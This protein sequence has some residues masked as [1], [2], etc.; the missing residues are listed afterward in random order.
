MARAISA[1]GKT[2]GAVLIERGYREGDPTQFLREIVQNGIEAG[3]TKIQLGI[4]WQSSAADWKVGDLPD[5]YPYKILPKRY[6]MVYYDNGKGMGERMADYLAGLLDLDSKDQSSGDLHGNF[7]MGA[8]ISTL[9]WNRAGLLVASWTPEFPEG[10][11]MWLRYVPDKSEGLGYYEAATLRW[12]DEDGLPMA[13]E[14][15]PAD[16]FPEFVDD[17]PEWLGR[18]INDDGDIGTGTMF[19]F[20]GNTGQ[21][22][23]FL[24]PENNWNTHTGPNYLT[25]RY[26]EHPTNLEI[27]YEDP[28]S[29][30][31]DSWASRR[32]DRFGRTTLDGSNPGPDD[33]IFNEP[34]RPTGPL[35]AGSFS[36]KGK[37]QMATI[38]LPDGGRIVINMIPEAAVQTGG[39]RRQAERPGIAVLYRGELYHR[40]EGA[41]DYQKFGISSAKVY[42]RLSITVE[43]RA[44]TS[45][46]DPLGGVFPSSS[47][48]SLSYVQPAGGATSG[49]DL[50]WVLWEQAFIDNMPKF[51]EEAIQA[52]VPD[53]HTDLDQDIIDKVA[54]PYMDMFKQ[55]KWFPRSNGPVAGTVSGNGGT[56]TVNGERKRR[57]GGGGGVDPGPGGGA[58]SAGSN[59]APDGS[60]P[61]DTKKVP[62]AIPECHFDAESFDDEEVQSKPR[63]AVKYLPGKTGQLGKIVMDPRFPL[64]QDVTQYWLDR[65]APPQHEDVRRAVQ[66]VYRTAMACRVGQILALT[67]ESGLTVDEVCS[68]FM[69]NS[70]LTASLFGLASEHAV[71]KQRLSGRVKKTPA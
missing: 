59:G 60:E 64:I 29:S 41:R 7:G 39:G 47:R 36:R 6:R 71:I 56:N 57:K 12:E 31:V 44:A 2:A 50:P 4:H 20:L 16:L 33:R 53:D 51:V 25:H 21:E 35:M 37:S 5:A 14:V 1:D 54:Q 24:G 13:S 49:R 70:A 28:R 43:P 66:I 30:D 55:V 32:R 61:G 65:T 46:H 58:G 10:R 67:K 45:V 27:R 17:R 40:R 18:P 69:T 26:W 3:A 38:P 22:N 19:L 15:A 11:F 8:R 62:A 34:V 42:R 9:P 68:S 23:T 52:A 48:T 63:I